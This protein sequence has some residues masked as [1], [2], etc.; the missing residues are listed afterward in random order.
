[1]LAPVELEMA[2]PTGPMGW[3][4]TNVDDLLKWLSV[5]VNA[6]VHGSDRVV[7]RATLEQMYL[8]HMFVYWAARD[9]HSPTTYGL[10][11]GMNTYRGHYHARL[12]GFGDGFESLVSFFP[13]DKMGVVLL[14]NRG[15]DTI[16]VLSAL[17]FEIT[18]RLLGLQEK[19]WMAWVR[20]RIARRRTDRQK[21]RVPA[22]VVSPPEPQALAD[23]A[24]IYT[25]RGYGIVEVV[26]EAGA[27][28]LSYNHVALALEY[29]GRDVFQVAA[30]C[31]HTSF[32]RASVRFNRS[33]T[34]TIASVSVRF[35][36]D[37]PPVQFERPPH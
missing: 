12:G 36:P 28:R 4:N 37:Q 6:G 31:K 3:I 17:K 20:Q 24:G 16:S 14:A 33:D 11:W 30:T 1:M 26:R 15:D 7:Q 5:Y 21:A 27:I 13:Q 19:D 35:D 2:N 25:N 23:Y 18:D 29:L 34:R 8:P 9:T 10:L 32:R 22:T